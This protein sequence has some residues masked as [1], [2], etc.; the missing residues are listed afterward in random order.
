ML[1]RLDNRTMPCDGAWAKEKVEAFRRW[2]PDSPFCAFKRR[3]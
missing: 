1:T 2:P 3:I